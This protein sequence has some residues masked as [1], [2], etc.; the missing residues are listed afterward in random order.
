MKKEIILQELITVTAAQFTASATPSTLIF[1][2]VIPG[3]ATS[4]DKRF[5]QDGVQRVTAVL[6]CTAH[7]NT[8]TNETYQFYLTTFKTLPSGTK[9]RWDLG[10]FI[11][12]SG[13]TAAVIQ[14]MTVMGQTTAPVL[15][16]ANGT[17][18]VDVSVLTVTTAGAGTG[19]RTI[20]AGL[21][22]HGRIGEGLSYSLVGGGTTPGP[23][24]YEL[25]CC[26]EY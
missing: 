1:D 23:I 25:A 17:T 4:A 11:V 13:A 7:D 26:V 21:V 19:I 6:R 12:I 3:T 20:G 2:N 16:A 18:G 5:G 22:R 15:Y 24:T 14:V 10:A 8:T 9:A